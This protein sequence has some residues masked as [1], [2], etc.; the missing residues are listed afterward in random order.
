VTDFRPFTIR[1]TIGG[2]VVRSTAGWHGAL[3]YG[4]VQVPFDIVD[5]T[6]LDGMPIGY[7]TGLVT[8]RIPPTVPW[9]EA[10]L[11]RGAFGPPTTPLDGVPVWY[12][13]GHD[14]HDPDQ[15]SQMVM[16]TPLTGGYWYYYTLFLYFGSPPTW[17]AA[18]TVALLVPRNYGTAEKLFS[19][20]PQF[21]QSTD[22]QQA[23]D[24]RNGPLRKFTAILGYDNDY[25]RTLLDGVLNVY[26][27]DRAPLKFVQLLGTNLGLPI[28]QAL[29]GARYRTLVGGLTQLE[30]L[31]GTS[32]GLEAF[33]YAA[34]NYRCDVTTGGNSLLTPDD[35][36]FVNGVGHWQK[37]LNSAITTFQNAISHATPAVPGDQW[38]NLVLRKYT[39]NASPPIPPVPSAGQGIMEII[40]LATTHLYTD[41]VIVCG[42]SPTGSTGG[43]PDAIQ[44]GI[45]VR[46]GELW[47]FSF[48]MVKPTAGPT[49]Q[50]VASWV[51]YDTNGVLKGVYQDATTYAPNGYLSDTGAWTKYRM[52]HIIA[53]GGDGLVT[54]PAGGICGYIIPCIWWH[55]P[56]AMTARY[57][58]GAML[59]SIKGVG[60]AIVPLPP[61]VYLT[62]GSTKL[63]NSPQS[64]LGPDPA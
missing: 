20:I 6:T 21:Y 40:D 55:A 5:G 24:G 32:I 54:D 31:R 42:L 35:A 50:V 52:Q 43:L 53:S 61:D 37:F 9:V 22:D 45:P 58:M 57:I 36:E 34:S 10:V 15:F 1:R 48:N 46:G 39:G 17:L 25:E 8:V 14:P 51:A 7:D 56:T 28:E 41:F 12:E 63:L 49:A 27:P 29:G 44:F 64:I 23:A 16:D 13:E 59:T 18:A 33:I 2:D 11:V 38:A 4:P 3:R 62:L 19:L 30:D 60:G 26:D 47:E